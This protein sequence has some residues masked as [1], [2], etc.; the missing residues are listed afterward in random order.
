LILFVC[1]K[2]PINAQSTLSPTIVTD[3]A[4]TN[5]INYYP[6]TNNYPS[7][8]SF[9]TSSQCGL[10]INGN[11]SFQNNGSVTQLGFSYSANKCTNSEK[12]EQLKLEN[13]IDLKKIESQTTITNQCLLGRTQAVVAGK[14]PDL[15]CSKP[16]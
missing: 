2:K 5:P 11:Q 6:P 8:P 1:L 3:P 15:I 9:N 13:S 10:S 4:T 12:L 14:D 7:T 16:Y